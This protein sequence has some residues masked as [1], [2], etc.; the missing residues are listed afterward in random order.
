MFLKHFKYLQ[1]KFDLFYTYHQGLNG[2]FND[3]AFHQR[4]ILSKIRPLPSLDAQDR[5]LSKGSS[6][7]G[8]WG[9][10]TGGA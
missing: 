8:D 7:D 10:L 2:I 1:Q 5:K 9:R 3:R 6:I 4:F